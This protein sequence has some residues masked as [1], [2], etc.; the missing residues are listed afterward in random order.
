MAIAEELFDDPGV[1]ML[2]GVGLLKTE[3]DHT[4]FAARIV[5]TLKNKSKNALHLPGFVIQ[6]LRKATGGMEAEE[7]AAIRNVATAL[8]NEKNKQEKGKQKKKK[9]TIKAGK[10]VSRLHDDVADFLSDDDGF[11]GKVDEEDFDFM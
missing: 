7:I 10:A 5:K 9:P 8:Y 11:E 1:T 2:E 3:D 4:E 6:L